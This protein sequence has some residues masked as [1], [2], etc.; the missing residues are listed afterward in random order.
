MTIKVDGIP[1]ASEETEI[2]LNQRE[3]TDYLDHRRKLVQWMQSIG[4]DREKAEGYARVTV[5]HRAYRTDAFYRRVWDKE[6]GY[7]T[8]VT[9]DHADSYMRELAYS[10]YSQDHKAN[11][12][13]AIKMLFRWRAWEFGD[14]PWDPDIYFGNDNTT[15]NPRDYL[16]R[17]ERTKLREA[18]LEYGSIPHYNAVTP[19]E[20]TKWA[21]YLAQRFGKPRN[22]IG[23]QDWERANGWKYPSLV[24]TSLDAGLRPVEVSC[25]NTGWLDLENGVLRIPKADS[26]KNRDNWTVAL[27]TRTKEVLSRWVEE[28]EVY[29]LYSNTDSLWL[30]REGNPYQSYS[31][32]HILEKLCDIAGIDT[33]NRKITWYS[34]RHSVGTYMAREEGLASAQA[35]LRH[36][37]QRT[38]MKY[39]QVPVEDRRNALDRMG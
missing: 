14:E 15:T 22:Q 34:L 19:E 28:R 16:T 24:M 21:A 37:S 30:T 32:N 36:K 20:R 11:L 31:L 33:Q 18:A 8:R 23:K 25:S 27:T 5:Y 1:L 35:Q 38:T 4:K 39:D 13:K 10:D 7:T 6:G 12:Q 29:D 9:H 3:L 26:S 2:R 17:D